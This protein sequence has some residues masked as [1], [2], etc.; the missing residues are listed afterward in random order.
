[1]IIWYCLT[2][3]LIGTITGMLLTALVAGSR[4]GD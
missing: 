3:W 2:S 4:K 1:M